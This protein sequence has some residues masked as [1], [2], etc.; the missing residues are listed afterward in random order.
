MSVFFLSPLAA[1]ATLRSRSFSSTLTFSEKLRV[2]SRLRISCLLMSTRG[3]AL[4]ATFY[5]V[6]SDD[7]IGLHLIDRLDRR[8]HGF[9]RPRT[10]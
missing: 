5:G 9:L 4:G 7:T 10:L 8:L 3:G 6:F 2:A 1:K